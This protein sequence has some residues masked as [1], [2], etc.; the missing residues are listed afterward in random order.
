MSRSR[1]QRI[2]WLQ[3]TCTLWMHSFIKHQCLASS[4]IDHLATLGRAYASKMTMIDIEF[5]LPRSRKAGAVATPT[6]VQV[7][8][9]P[10]DKIQHSFFHCQLSFTFATKQVGFLREGA[11]IYSLRKQDESSETRERK[12]LF[13]QENYRE[14]GVYLSGESHTRCSK[15]VRTACWSIKQ[16]EQVVLFEESEV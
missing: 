11:S 16:K 3:M 4:A 7:F 1:V 13:E 15:R 6:V 12:C 9:V 14:A 10:Q 2:V 8:A 5:V